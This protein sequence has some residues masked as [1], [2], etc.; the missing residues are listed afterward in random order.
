MCFINSDSPKTNV[1]HHFIVC[2]FGFGFLKRQ[3]VALCYGQGERKPL[4]ENLPPSEPDI[5]A[6][7]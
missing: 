3:L 7:L 6:V 4:P 1:L 5:Y 2:L